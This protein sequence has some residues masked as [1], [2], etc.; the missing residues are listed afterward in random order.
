M[1]DNR[2]D[3]QLTQLLA[4]W[5]LLI[6]RAILAYSFVKAGYLKLSNWA[7]TLYLFE[8]EYQVPILSFELAAYL[9]T[10]VEIIIPIAL[11]IGSYTR[12]SA[13]IL[14]A[15]NAIAV[16][17]YPV[18]WEQGFYDHR[19]WAAMLAALV[20]WGAGKYSFDGWRASRLNSL[21]QSD[22]LR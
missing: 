1:N 20:V 6:F 11:I 21:D 12:L 8:Y 10:A 7:G 18:L 22:S 3:S 4:P 19:Y 5:L 13:A 17:S 15:F 9:G 16:Y 2:F 14:F